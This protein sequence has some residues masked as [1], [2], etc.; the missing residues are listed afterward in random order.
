M[1]RVAQAAIPAS[2]TQGRTDRVSAELGATALVADGNEVRSHDASV[3]VRLP[4]A[5]PPTPLGHALE[6]W[7]CRSIAGSEKNIHVVADHP[8]ESIA[9]EAT[10]DVAAL[11]HSTS[12]KHRQA[13]HRNTKGGS[14]AHR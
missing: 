5:G 13:Q 9:Q 10:K 2:A 1:H 7:D 11:H 8:L 14:H 12:E 3:L 6:V 4:V